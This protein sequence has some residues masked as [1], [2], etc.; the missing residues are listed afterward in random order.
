MALSEN[1]PDTPIL[2]KFIYCF[3]SPRKYKEAMNIL[4]TVLILEKN[5]YSVQL[6]IHSYVSWPD[7][8]FKGT[9]SMGIFF[10]HIS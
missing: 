5:N 6:A 2:H 8:K 9:I 1:N 10:Y 7:M 4:D 3:T